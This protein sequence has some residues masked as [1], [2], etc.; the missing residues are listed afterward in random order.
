MFK[1][2]TSIIIGVLI[3]SLMATGLVWADEGTPTATDSPEHRLQ[4]RG[5]EITA[6]GA[7]NFTLTGPRGNTQTFYVDSATEFHNQDGDPITFADLEVGERAVVTARKDGDRL[8][9]TRVRV[10][11]PRSHYKGFGTVDSVDA[12]E[13]AFTFTNRRGKTWEFYVDANTEYTDRDGGTH[14]FEDLQAGGHVFVKAELRA[15]GKWWA[16]LIGFPAQSVETQP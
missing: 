12:A 1:K 4:R 11:P 16:T 15:D 8:I 6:L 14:S 9:A 10:F 5:G 3:V 7:N 13:Q 2:L